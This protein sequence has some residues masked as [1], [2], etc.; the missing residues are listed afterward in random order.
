M[1]SVKNQ[2]RTQKG[3]QVLDFTED[4]ARAYFERL[5]WPEGPFCLGC[6]SVGV[7]RVGGTAARPGLFEC[8]DCRNQFTVTTNSVMHDTHLPLATWAKAFHLMCS[9]KK[10]VSA[11]Q[12]Q[13]NLGLGSY[14]TAWHLAHRIREAMKCEP[15]AGM[16]GR[17]GKAVEVDE[18]F[19]GP[20]NKR[21]TA[22]RNNKKVVVALI[23]RDGKAAVPAVANI[24]GKT[25]KSVVRAHCDR[26]AKIYTDGYWSY[27]GLGNEF[28][29]HETVNHGKH[30]YARGDVHVNNCESFFGLMRRG[31]IGSFHH[32]SAE[33]AH[34]YA[35]EFCFRWNGRKLTDAERRDEA[36]RNA[37]GKRLP[38]KPLKTP[39]TPPTPPGYQF[40]PFPL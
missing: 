26:D 10:G 34:R 14:R 1:A 5:R 30:E 9:A 15:V 20:Q 22:R 28:A 40:P 27:R 3:Q 35:A 23:E 2:A 8:R 37:E 16:L 21:S 36:V 32:I 12:L 6:G 7:Y 31:I 25:L 38:L 29:S 24:S 18:V 4:E 19:L 33:H 11:L 17:G 13:R 39:K